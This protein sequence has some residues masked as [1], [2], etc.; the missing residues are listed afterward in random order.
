MTLR[1]DHLLVI[2][3]VKTAKREGRWSLV[4]HSRNPTQTVQV[5]QWF[6][7]ANISFTRSL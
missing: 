6:E 5:E 3:G 4:V 2:Q 7:T 1:P